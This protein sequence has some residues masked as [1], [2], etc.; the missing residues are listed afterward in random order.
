MRNRDSHQAFSG[1]DQAG[2]HVLPSPFPTS[3]RAAR[4]RATRPSLR[5]A[6][7]LVA[8]ALGT[9]LAG[10][11]GPADGLTPSYAGHVSAATPGAATKTAASAR[12][13]GTSPSAGTLMLDWGDP[14]STP[15]AWRGNYV[16]LQ[17]WEYARIPSLRAHNPDIRVLM[18]K[19]VSATV[20]GACRD[21]C[22]R[23]NEILPTGVGYHWAQQHHPEWFLHDAAGHRLEWS[24]WPGLFPMDI[25]D[26]GYQR[27][28]LRSVRSELRAHDWDGVMMDDVLTT[29]SHS[30]FGDRVSTR[31]PDDAAMYAGTERFL[32]R[33]APRFQRSGFLAVPNLTVGWD[34]WKDVLEDWTPYVSGWENEYF[35][36]WSLGPSELFTA[37]DDWTW[38]T[39]MARWLARRDVP[40]LAITYSS[41]DDVAAQAYHRASWLLT[42][43]GRTGSSIFVPEESDTDHWLPVATTDIGRPVSPPEVVAGVVHR[44][45]YTGGAVLVNPTRDARTVDL[46]GTFTTLRG[47]RV[48]SVRLAP[49]SGV[50]L[51]D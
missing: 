37:D 11:A 17:P 5:G 36:K 21:G 27:R 41:R 7:G 15:D 38:K 16:V 39:E 49:T 18:Y 40:L 8:L 43:N 26:P 48:S 13:S 35:V 30:T 24:D 29:L 3:Q 9:V 44:R 47:K 42:W 20:E 25:A 50:I 34:N 22:T 12:G 14:Q 33:V 45:D 4:R 19:D 31:F 32:R 10:S 46:D 2:D 6:V 28:W 1:P 23:D 51:R